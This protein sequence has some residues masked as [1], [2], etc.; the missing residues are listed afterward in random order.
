MAGRSSGYGVT[1]TLC[2]TVHVTLANLPKNSWCLCFLL[3]FM[4]PINVVVE[5][6]KSRHITV[7][8][9]TQ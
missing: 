6:G 5:K 7:I 4:E 9:G 2:L 8:S 3:C 1:V